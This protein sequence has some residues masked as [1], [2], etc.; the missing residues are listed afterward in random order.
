VDKVARSIE[1]FGFRQ[2]IVVDRE[3]IVVAGHTRLLAA[4]KLKL[5]TVPVHV[6][7][8]LTPEQ[9]RAYRL[10][11]NRVAEFSAW[12]IQTLALEIEGLKEA[13]FKIEPLGF[14][15]LELDQLKA[16]AAGDEEVEG[17]ASDEE[18]ADTSGALLDLI[19]VTIAE[20]RHKVERGDVWLLDKRHRLFCAGV[21]TDWH[22][23][24]PFLAGEAIFC[25][26]PGPFVAYGKKAREH[27]LVMVQPDPYTAGH[28]LD[29]FAEIHGRRS[30]RKV[31]A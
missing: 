21:M 16:A 27:P 11:D 25:P 22:L 14:T 19:K 7:A 26:Y 4:R 3:G 23:W 18:P 6:A 24:A 20:P 2:P 28:V 15:I 9:A 8:D 17:R 1:A 31:A 30:V 12:D 5:K 13:D 10:A 29:R